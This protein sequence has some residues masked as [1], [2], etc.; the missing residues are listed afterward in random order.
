MRPVWR[1]SGRAVG[2]AAGLLTA[3]PLYRLSA[4]DSVRISE[5][6]TVLAPLVES[7]G[8]SS[9][10]GPVREA[11]KR[12]LPAWAKSETDTA[13]NLWVRVG[14]GGPV[15]AFIA[16]LDEIGFRVSGIRDD[17]TLELETRGAFFSSLFEA[18]PALVH[19]DRGEVAGIFLPRDSGFTRRTPPPLRVD[20]GAGSR[21]GAMARGV[22]PGATVTM[23]KQYVRLA[24]T[25]ATGRS[26][27]DR[28]GSAAQLLALRRL[29]RAA[30]KHQVIF[31]WSVREEI[32]LEGAEAAA[33]TLGMMPRRVYAIDTFVSADS[34]LE[35]PNFAV[36]PIGRGAV[37]RALDNS[38][39]TPPAYV[40]SLV[41]VA[42]ARGVALQVGTTNGGNDGSVFTPYGVVD[43][44]I[45]WPLRYSHSPVEV[46]DLK[47]VVSLADLIRAVA[48]TW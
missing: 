32:G 33:A 21:A 39:V 31:I 10:E 14:Q 17:G 18:Q 25:R 19:T 9:A 12:L 46:V 24:G 26:F 16:H 38:S 20:V 29:D 1:Y 40:D 34:P 23:P 44:A 27:D 13:G 45:G 42:R 22:S 11:V 7:Y 8:V 35:P 2:T 48:E 47:D 3:L 6:Q 28:V 30:L 36:A 41:Q 5:A 15:V 4:Q 43:V 37:A